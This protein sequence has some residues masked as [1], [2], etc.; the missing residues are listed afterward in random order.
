M[1][2]FITRK[3][4]GYAE[5]VCQQNKNRSYNCGKSYSLY[6]IIIRSKVLTRSKTETGKLVIFGDVLKWD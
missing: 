5:S 4:Y 6:N 3:N 1:Y 2:S